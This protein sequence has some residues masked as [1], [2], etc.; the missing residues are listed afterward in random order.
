[1]QY[2]NV[3]LCVD[4][5]VLGEFLSK[6]YWENMSVPSLKKNTFFWSIFNNEDEY[7]EFSKKIE[8]ARSIKLEL[9]FIRDYCVETHYKEKSE[10]L[11]SIMNN[12]I[13]LL[14]WAKYNNCL[15]GFSEEIYSSWIKIAIAFKSYAIRFKICSAS[16]DPA[17]F[18]SK[19]I[20]SI[21]KKNTYLEEAEI[22]F[23]N[24][25]NK[26]KIL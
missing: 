25:S 26:K 3:L 15:K 9:I 2:K 10:M 8:V 19:T 4:L 14:S 6:Q 17:Y 24:I 12:T 5:F 16:N 7:K 22:V 13:S 23:S 21:G 1:M 18:H 11:Y 20:D